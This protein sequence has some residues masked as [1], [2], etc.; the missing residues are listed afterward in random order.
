MADLNPAPLRTCGDLSNLVLFAALVPDLGTK[1][2]EMF[3]GIPPAAQ[4]LLLMDYCRAP[5]VSGVH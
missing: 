4:G 2:G 5:P 3:E 1:P